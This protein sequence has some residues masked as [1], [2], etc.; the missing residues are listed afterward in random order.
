[1]LGVVVFVED[2]FFCILC[3]IAL[4]LLFYECNNGKIRYPVIPIVGAGF[5]LYRGTLG[6][7][8]MLFSEVIAFA[9][10]AA[11]R[12][13]C[14]FL[15]FPVRFACKWIRT[16]VQKLAA[17]LAASRRKR[18]RLRYTERV[19]TQGL[20]NACGLIPEILPKESRVK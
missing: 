11:F 10:G 9:I 5:L 15:L 16:G 3:G 18:E 2:L 12:Y 6:K 19:S 1:M 20:Q 4:I 7:L 8:V 14:F 13:V 17:R